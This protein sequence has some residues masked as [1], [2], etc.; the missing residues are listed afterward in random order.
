[1]R[2]LILLLPLLLSACP[3]ESWSDETRTDVGTVCV[4]GEADG[5]ATVFVDSQE[6]MSSSCSRNSTG[7]CAATLD[8]STVTVT[9][10]FTWE[11]ATGGVPC[12]D[13][14]GFLGTT[15]E[16]GPLPAGEYTIVHGSDTVTV[17]IPTEETCG[18]F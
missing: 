9:S 13:D 12:T 18:G 3:L 10:T 14:C 4:E 15:C 5:T 17:T 2:P 6:C 8:G 16:V 1:M 11:Q 7:T